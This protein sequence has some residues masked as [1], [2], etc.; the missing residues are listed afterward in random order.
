MP[1]TDRE[2]LCTISVLPSSSCARGTGQPALPSLH[3]SYWLMRQAITLLPT[4]FSLLRQVLAGCYEPLLGDGPSRRYLYDPC[5]GA[6]VPTPPRLSGAHVRFFPDHIGLILGV[7]DSAREKYPANSFTQGDF[8][9]LQPFVYLQAPLLA[10]PSG[11]SDLQFPFGHRALYTAQYLYRH[12]IQ[13]AASLRVRI[14]TID[15]TGLG[16][17]FAARTCWIAAL[18]AAPTPTCLH[19]WPRR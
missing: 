11:C 6:W 9:R 17:A 2:P 1:T 5:T 16:S 4:L 3:S 19:T 13:A 10:R 12:R 14:R 15:T 8:S 18:S 7:R